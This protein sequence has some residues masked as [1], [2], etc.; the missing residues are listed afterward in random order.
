MSLGDR[1]KYSEKGFDLSQAIEEANRCILCYDA[2]CSKGC[3]GKTKPGEFIRKLRLRNIT[4]AIRTIKTNNILGGSCGVLCPAASLCEKECSTRALDRPIRIGK[5]QAALI[6]YSWKMDFKMFEKPDPKEEKVAVVGAGPAGLSCAADLAKDGYQVTIFEARPEPGGVL[7]YGVPAYRFPESFI[8]KEIEDIKSLGVEIKCSTAITGEKAVENLLQEGFDAVFLA[9]GLWQ[10]M[11]LKEE[12]TEN[13]GVFTCIEF[14]AALREG[15]HD[16]MAESFAGKTAAVIG[17]G[18]VAIDCVESAVKLGAADVYLVYRRSY[19]QMPAEEE[20]KI[21]A[22]NQGVHFLLLNQPKAYVNSAKSGNLNGLLMVRTRLGEP[23]A[24]G[25]RRPI[26]IREGGWILDADVVIEAIGTKPADES[27]AWYPSVKVTAD[28]LVLVNEETGETSK[29]GVFA[30][31]DIIR[32][33]GFVVMA[34]QDGKQSAGA[35]KQYLQN[36]RQ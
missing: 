2:P 10:A 32:G 11:R 22:L 30:G 6:E 36:R 21:S 19:S 16:T 12:P 5:I 7:R 4:G 25:R 14:L 15:K 1:F 33:P 35:I 34:V 31:G 3:P 27:P 8:K 17:G 24:S 28:N 13:K 9:P 29:K 23:D 18:S 26:E 20:E